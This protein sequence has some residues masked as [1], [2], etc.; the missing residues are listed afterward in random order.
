MSLSFFFL[1]FYDF[2]SLQHHSLGVWDPVT[3]HV[4]SG[5]VK[6]DHV[7]YSFNPNSHWLVCSCL[8]FPVSKP[9]VSIHISIL[10][11]Q[12]VYISTPG[13]LSLLWCKS[14]DITQRSLPLLASQGPI[15]C[16]LKDIVPQSTSQGEG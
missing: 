7:G 2:C 13:L 11:S 14:R 1:L 3:L 6:S 9:L 12:V 15:A 4:S 16:G 5:V 8:M 10:L